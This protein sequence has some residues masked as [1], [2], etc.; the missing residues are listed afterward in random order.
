MFG[1]F[2]E[3]LSFFFFAFLLSGDSSAVAGNLNGNLR[4]RIAQVNRKTK[5]DGWK[6]GDGEMVGGVIGGWL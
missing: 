1:V 6:E 5:P 2:S 4:F 3:S